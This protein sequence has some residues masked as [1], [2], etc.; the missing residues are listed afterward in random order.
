MKRPPFA[1]VRGG[2]CTLY[3][4]NGSI[5]PV[6]GTSLIETGSY[7]SVK[8]PGFRS[9][10]KTNSLPLNPHSWANYREVRKSGE[11]GGYT[12]WADR[13]TGYRGFID[14]YIDGEKLPYR[15]GPEGVEQKARNAVLNSL[16]SQSVNLAQA[17]A[18]RRQTASMLSKSV[19]RIATA[20]LAIRHGNLRHAANMFGMKY[21]RSGRAL[22]REIPP[23]P[24]NLSNWWLEYSYGWRPLL[25]DIHGAAELIAKTY[26]FAR[27]TIAYGQATGSTFDK[28]IQQVHTDSRSS[29]V[30]TCTSSQQVRARYVIEFVEDDATRSRLAQTGITNPLELAWELLPYSFVLDWFIPVGEYLKTFDATNGLSFKRGTLS[31]VSSGTHDSGWTPN[32]AEISPDG[33]GP[34]VITGGGA[35]IEYTYKSRSV[36]GGFPSPAFPTF[37]PSLGVSRTLSGLALLTQAFKR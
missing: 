36:L 20:A 2:P 30:L 19:N 9:A 21:G 37:Q 14:D 1:G 13:W 7:S 12:A 5:T 35:Y 3:S 24:K 18:E 32:H 29:S 33:S 26:E 17:F 23:S 6:G 25:Q 28:Y 8:T 11:W 22:T 31:V 34:T 4:W 27:P 15:P 10:R 16:K